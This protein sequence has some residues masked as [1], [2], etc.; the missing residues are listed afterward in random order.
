MRKNKE[1]GER[2]E[3]EKKRWKKREEVKESRY[4]EWQRSA[5]ARAI[6]NAILMEYTHGGEKSDRQAE[7]W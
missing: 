5:E 7:Q 4:P 2:A 1:N 3:G 6:G